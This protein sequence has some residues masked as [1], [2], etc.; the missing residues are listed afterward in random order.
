MMKIKHQTQKK[1]NGMMMVMVVTEIIQK[2]NMIPQI[3]P[4]NLV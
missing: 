2:L 3:H 4:P 1:L